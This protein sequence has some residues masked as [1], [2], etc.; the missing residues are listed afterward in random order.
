M[1]VRRFNKS[2]SLIIKKS[3]NS[4]INISLYKIVKINDYKRSDF[5]SLN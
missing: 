5:K 4:R 3:V 2:R 1:R